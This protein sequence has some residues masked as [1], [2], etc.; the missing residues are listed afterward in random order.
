MAPLKFQLTKKVFLKKLMA[1]L[2]WFGSMT[3]G[4]VIVFLLYDPFI[5]KIKGPEKYLIYVVGDFTDPTAKMVKNRLDSSLR[6]NLSI[7]NVPIDLIKREICDNGDPERA[8]EIATSLS[9]KNDIL[10]IVGHFYSSTTKKAIPKYM[11]P[12]PPIA[13]ILTTETNPYLISSAIN[14][15]DENNNHEYAPI[16]GLSPDDINQ[17][18]TAVDF[19]EKQASRFWIIHDTENEVYSNFL[20]QEFKMQMQRKNNKKVLLYTDNTYIPTLETFEELE[21]DGV[22]FAGDWKN[23]LVIMNQI[24]SI[25]KNQRKPFILLSD[26][27][28]DE[29]LLKQGDNAIENV[30]LTY[31]LT[32]QQFYTENLGVYGKNAAKEINE[33]ITEA[34]NHYKESLISNWLG[35]NRVKYAREAIQNA[36]KEMYDNE[37]RI[38]SSFIVWQVVNDSIENKYLYKQIVNP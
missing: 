4:V 24:N 8:E 35:I 9:K 30:Y 31:P 15:N 5:G 22:Y 21:I 37:H 17:A 34:N 19:A 36:M 32:P 23:A 33:I 13:L 20:A 10:F 3:V 14:S 38:A 11:M 29:E 2:K 18:K 28:V 7:D 1:F 26:G 6:K 27:C 12:D 25:L 16:Y